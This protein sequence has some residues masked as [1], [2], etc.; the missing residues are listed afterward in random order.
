MVLGL[1]FFFEEKDSSMLRKVVLDIVYRR[2][3]FKDMEPDPNLQK[4]YA[5]AYNEVYSKHQF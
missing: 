5:D 3:F 1:M 4:M 2:G